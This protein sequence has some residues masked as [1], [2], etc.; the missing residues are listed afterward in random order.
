ML[1]GEA[2]SRGNNA[3]L[4]GLFPRVGGISIVVYY[5]HRTSTCSIPTLDFP[6][7]PLTTQPR[8]SFPYPGFYVSG[9]NVECTC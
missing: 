7:I 9:R 6:S 1:P 4:C 8:R 5:F 3:L 2:R